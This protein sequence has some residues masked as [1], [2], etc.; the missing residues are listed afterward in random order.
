MV[1]IQ[2][3]PLHEKWRYCYA[4]L[5]EDYSSVTIDDSDWDWTTFTEIPNLAMSPDDV[6]WLRKRFDLN[7]TE[8]CI[9]YFLRCDGCAYPMTIYLRGQAIAHYDIGSNLDVDVTDYVSLDDNILVLAI[10]FGGVGLDLQDVKLYLQ[11][12]FCDDLN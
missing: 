8:A 5:S 10:R 1:L 12:I 7:P 9:R 6:I 3:I 2:K 4:T 11:P